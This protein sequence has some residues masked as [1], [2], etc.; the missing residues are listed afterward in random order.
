M[1]DVAMNVAAGARS[2][3]ATH[4]LSQQQAML[5]QGSTASTL[6]AGMQLTR[7]HSSRRGSAESFGSAGS[8][9]LQSITAPAVAVTHHHLGSAGSSSK[10]VT[11]NSSSRL[12]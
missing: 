6:S 1:F 9:P 5:A 7:S 12:K 2:D 3:A 10:L 4:Q 11:G 8:L